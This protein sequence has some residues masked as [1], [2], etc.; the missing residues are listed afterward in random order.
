V[1]LVSLGKQQFREIGSVLSGN[2]CYECTK[3]IMLINNYQVRYL[4]L[5][6]DISTI[7]TSIISCLI[8]R[9]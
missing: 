7:I 8:W 4:P 2:S 5:S 6:S 9:E 1:D 3:H